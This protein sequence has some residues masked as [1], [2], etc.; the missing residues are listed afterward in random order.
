MIDARD[1]N[2]ENAWYNVYMPAFKAA[3]P[4]HE[5]RERLYEFLFQ[6]LPLHTVSNENVIYFNVELE[7]HESIVVSVTWSIANDPPDELDQRHVARI[8]LAHLAGMALKGALT[9]METE[10]EKWSVQPTEGLELPKTVH[11]YNSPGPITPTH[12]IPP[13]TMVVLPKGE[14]D[15]E[16]KAR[17]Y[18][19]LVSVLYD[20]N[21]Q[22]L[23]RKKNG[24]GY[25]MFFR[26]D[27]KLNLPRTEMLDDK[28]MFLNIWEYKNALRESLR[29]D[30]PM[31][32]RLLEAI[33]RCVVIQQFPEEIMLQGMR[34]EFYTALQKTQ[35]EKVTTWFIDSGLGTKEFTDVIKGHNMKNPE[36]SDFM[37]E[38]MNLFKFE[39]KGP[40]GRDFKYEGDTSSDGIDKVRRKLIN[41]VCNYAN[42]EEKESKDEIKRKIF[43]SKQATV[44]QAAKKLKGKSASAAATPQRKTMVNDVLKYMFGVEKLSQVEPHPWHC[45]GGEGGEGGEGAM[46][47]DDRGA[48]SGES[49]DDGGAESG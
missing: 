37:T 23:H 19:Q 6:Y 9:P 11:I 7:L 22:Y 17:F 49:D 43:K 25:T 18:A 10:E 8:R 30:L 1:N 2:F 28:G 5:A 35:P 16:L 15:A 12:S 32:R 34:T 27:V 47:D 4:L 20:A 40:K 26:R 21:L 39:A 42:T 46:R 14:I 36:F 33:Y 41:L 24:S 29:K 31:S 13:V 48:E 3:K 44:A 45:E 38:V